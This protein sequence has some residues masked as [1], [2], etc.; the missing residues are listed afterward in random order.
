MKM[1]IQIFSIYDEKAKAYVNTFFQPHVG[2]ALRAF[3]NTTKDPKT[4]IHNNPED[5]S[6][7]HI[8]EFDDSSA[9]IK[10]FNEPRFL[11][12]ATEHV[13]EPVPVS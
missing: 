1:K 12:K 4:Q 6:L 5:F 10:S 9:N 11:S 3:V 13:N 7:Y 2:Q 8:G